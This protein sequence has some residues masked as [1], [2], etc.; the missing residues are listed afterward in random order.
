MMWVVIAANV[1]VFFVQND[2]ARANPEQPAWLDYAIVPALVSWNDPL[3]WFPLVSSQFLHGGLGH[4]ISNLWILW[5]FGDNVE[6]RM[7]PLL[8]AVF[9]IACGCVAGLVHI[10]FG[11][12][13][14]VPTIG[15]SGAIAGVLGAYLVLYPHARVLTLVPL[16]FLPLVYDLPAYFFLILW[17]GLQVLNGSL[18]L[19]TSEAL[20]SVAWWAH[21][22]GFVAGALL[23]R[24]F[25]RRRL[26]PRELQLDE[27]TL[28]DL[29][30]RMR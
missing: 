26:H 11:P 1:L 25:A 16:L 7:G 17:F 18:S 4:L 20:S 28:Q 10:A 19:F 6:D 15:A 2:L 21:V 9:Y 27:W 8:F 24:L 23:C 3:T 5:I 29:W 22:G 14:L 13:S 12:S 30:K